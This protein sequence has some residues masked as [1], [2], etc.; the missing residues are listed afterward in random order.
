MGQDAGRVERA[1]QATIQTMQEY[2]KWN[3]WDS[4][5]VYAPDVV[6]AILEFRGDPKV[7]IDNPLSEDK[8]KWDENN[9]IKV[10]TTT[11]TTDSDLASIY[12]RFEDSTQ[13]YVAQI[14]RNANGEVSCLHFIKQ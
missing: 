13:K 5:V 4:K 11:N 12:T 8:N 6:S 2:R 14:E 7:Q 9:I 1:N 3:S 10:Y